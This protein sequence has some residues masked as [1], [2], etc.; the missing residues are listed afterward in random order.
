MFDVIFHPRSLWRTREVAELSAKV[1]FVQA[2]DEKFVLRVTSN[3]KSKQT[4]N[5]VAMQQSLPEASTLKFSVSYS[6]GEYLSIVQDHIPSLLAAY[7]AKRGKP[8]TRSPKLLKLLLIPVASVGFYFKKRRMPICHFTIDREG[9]QRVTQDGILKFPWSDVVAV[10]RY[11]LG[12]VVEKS[13]GAVPL[14]HRCMTP[15][16][17]KMFEVFTQK[18]RDTST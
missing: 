15:E 3:T 16:Q 12:Y 13:K 1:P 10:H 4:P 9:I 2:I 6:L 7:E 8:L 18:W 14:P 5:L 11:T 17:T